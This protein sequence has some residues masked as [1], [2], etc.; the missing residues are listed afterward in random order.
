MRRLRRVLVGGQDPV[1][2]VGDRRRGETDQVR[3]GVVVEV[4]DAPAAVILDR[5]EDP[6]MAVEKTQ[7]AAVVVLDKLEEV[8]RAVAQLDPVAALASE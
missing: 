7:A 2:E 4:A 3:R 8:L 6:A 5:L 1:G